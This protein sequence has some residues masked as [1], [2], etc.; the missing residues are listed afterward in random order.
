MP[1][2]RPELP[3]ALGTPGVRAHTLVVIRWMSIAGQSI[4]FVVVETVL[5]FDTPLVA[6]GLAI[7]AAVAAN[8]ALMTLYPR[9]SRLVGIRAWLNLAFDVLQLGVLIYL[10]GGLMNPFVVLLLAPV[11]ISATLLT[12]RATLALALLATA[13]LALVAVRSLPLPWHGPPPAAPPQLLLAI[14]VAVAFTL[15]F[16]GAY[17]LSVALDARRW[18]QALVV[19][20]AV[21]ERE[22]KMSALGALAAASAHELGGPLGTI[23]LVAHDLSQTLGGDPDFGDDV[24]LLDREARRCRTILT[25]LARRAEVETPFRHVSLLALLHEAAQGFAASGKLSIGADVPALTVE[26]SPELLHG[27]VNLLDNAVRHADRSVGLTASIDA[28]TVSIAIADDGPGFPPDLLRNIGDPYL[29]PA[30][31]ARGG[32]GLGLF[33]ATTLIGRTGGKLLFRNVAGGGAT[34]EIRWR[35]AYIDVAQRE[36]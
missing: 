22:T 5:G 1:G 10:T 6:A 3:A 16:L 23:A 26:R 21:L 19:T 15:W 25:D 28:D 34:V 24:A 17:V 13:V 27:I 18:Q 31:S 2:I 8:I 14:F 35:R 33:I 4:A 29:G 11:T 12:P 32:T 36:T 9:G 7:L 30:R 20:Q